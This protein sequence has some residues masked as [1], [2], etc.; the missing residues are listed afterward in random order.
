MVVDP[1][2]SKAIGR[3]RI[4]MLLIVV[5]A[6]SLTAPDQVN[7]VLRRGDSLGRFLLERVKY[8]D[9]VLELHRID[10]PIRVAVIRCD[11]FKHA[12]SAESL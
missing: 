12:A 9:H 2:V 8:I 11:D 7:L 10:G 4:F 6:M 3:S 5:G 1:H